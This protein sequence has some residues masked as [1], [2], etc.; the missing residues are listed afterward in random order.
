MPDAV[1]SRVN[2][3][4]WR[5][6]PEEDGAH[7]G[8]YLVTSALSQSRMCFLFYTYTSRTHT[9]SFIHF[10]LVFITD[11]IS[12]CSPDCLLS[13]PRASYLL[14][15]PLLLLLII[16]FLT[17]SRRFPRVWMEGFVR[18]SSAVAPAERTDGRGLLA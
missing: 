4:G 14:P 5:T 18:H 8:T 15:H 12:H 7:T 11:C 16:T 13:C 1:T 3:P 9:L 6:F 10:S 2:Y 17:S